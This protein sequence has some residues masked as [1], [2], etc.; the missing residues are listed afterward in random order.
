MLLPL[1]ADRAVLRFGR[2][3]PDSSP[4]PGAF[5]FYNGSLGNP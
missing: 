3:G 5:A 2:L 1:I 4:V